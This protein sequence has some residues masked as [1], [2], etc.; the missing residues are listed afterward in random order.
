MVAMVT[1]MSVAN[2][3]YSTHR[4]RFR[5]AESS[6]RYGSDIETRPGSEKC[7]QQKKRGYRS[8]AVV[9]QQHGHSRKRPNPW[10][11]LL[12]QSRDQGFSVGVGRFELPASTSRMTPD[13]SVAYG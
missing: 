11:G 6:R 3:E 5:F 13:Q 7:G 8:K 12:S 10:S 9:P 1:T 2:F 4:K